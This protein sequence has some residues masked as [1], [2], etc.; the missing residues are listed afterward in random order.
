MSD[1]PKWDVENTPHTCEQATV[2]KLRQV[3]GADVLKVTGAMY[4][5]AVLDG[6]FELAKPYSSELPGRVKIRCGWFGVNPPTTEPQLLI[7]TCTS[8]VRISKY[9]GEVAD[10]ISFEK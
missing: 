4:R 9:C 7:S 1:Y 3:T 2:T 5:G 10:D 6:I 8:C